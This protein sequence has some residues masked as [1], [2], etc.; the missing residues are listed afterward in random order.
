MTEL[1]EYKRQMAAESAREAASWAA[2]KKRL[3][4]LERVAEAARALV[5]QLDDH[6]P[7]SVFNANPLRTALAELEAT[8]ADA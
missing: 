7:Y 5:E 6:A 3:R 4:K 1:D 2:D 8:D